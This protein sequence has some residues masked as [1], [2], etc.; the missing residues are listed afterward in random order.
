MGREVLAR[1]DGAAAADE[2]YQRGVEVRLAGRQLVGPRRVELRGHDG[3]EGRLRALPAGVH[4]LD[5]TAEVLELGGGVAAD[6]QHALVHCRVAEVGRPRH[7]QALDVALA[8]LE[9][10]ARL[11][12]QRRAVTIVG[13]GDHV[14][15]GGGVAHGAR[16]RAGVGH[17][18]PAG[19]AGRLRHPPVGGLEADEA[20]EGRRDPHRAA[21]VGAEADRSQ[22]GRHR[23]GGAAAGA[24]R[25]P[26]EVPRIA[27]GAE[28]R[29]VGQ[30]LVAEL[31]EVRLAED[32]GA[33]HAQ[34][35]DGDVVLLG[36][37][38]GE[39]ARSAGGGEAARVERVLDRHRHAV[40][41]T[42]R[43][44]LHHGD[45]GLAGRC[46]GHAGADEAERVQPRV[47]R[48]DAGQQRLGELD[49]RELLVTDQRGDLE[50]GSP[51]KIVM[52]QGKTLRIRRI[53]S[54]GS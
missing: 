48:L 35:G 5:V 47:Q 34:A 18:L 22:P 11:P 12:R 37:Q 45:L 14:E 52:N 27:R 39:E 38:L 1:G 21:P 8:G 7:V 4:D 20:A 32:D 13:A 24:A 28:H 40:Q 26:L 16:Q 19:E 51:G 2:A 23:G 25:R 54:S 53:V 6:L 43:L 42:D 50:G 30:R 46:P 36:Q 17:V 41:R 44:P 9:V 29:V 15:H 31:R 33:G 49:G 10:R 3:G